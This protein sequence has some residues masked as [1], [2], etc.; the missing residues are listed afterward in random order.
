VEEGK[1]SKKTKKQQ[2]RIEKSQV[3]LPPPGVYPRFSAMRTSKNVPNTTYGSMRKM[4]YDAYA[5]MFKNH[6]VIYAAINK[7]AAVAVSGGWNFNGPTTDVVPSEAHVRELSNF[8]RRSNGKQLMRL[9]FMD[10]DIFGE[11]FWL[12]VRGSDTK[13]TPIKA[14][15]LE[16]KYVSEVVD[17]AG[18]LSSWE[19]G[20][21]SGDT[22]AV[23][24]GLDEVIQYKLDDPTDPIRGFS[25]LHSLQQAVAQDLFAMEY[26][27][28]F[29]KNSAQTGI[30]FIVKTSTKEEAD[31]NRAWIEENYAGPENAHRPLLIEGDVDVKQ[32]VSK[33]AEM[34]FLAGRKLL[35]Q[36]MLMALEVDPDKVGIHEDSNRSVS[37]EMEEAFHSQ[38]IAP[39]QVV[40]EE[41]INNQ[42]ILDMY[43]W[44]DVVI[45]HQEGD[46]RQAMR[47][48]EM[49][50]ENV[51]GGRMTI[52]AARK[53][54]GQPAVPGGDNAFINSP[55]GIVFVE[56]FDK[57]AQEQV[58]NAGPLQGGIQ[59]K[60]KQEQQSRDK[61]A[62]VKN[63]DPQ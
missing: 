9:T 31:R 45:D 7:K 2:M 44:D 10:L 39:R 47:D 4:Q 37:K 49:F 13:R 53:A 27:K 15:R 16:P 17:G 19:Y 55:T 8:M 59:A 43:G 23:S 25:P 41:G 22:T 61:A 1:M 14:L 24:Y 57:M 34:E 54:Q 32:S 3:A 42:L 12:I 11:S 51:Y 63:N 30:V 29:F 40:I 5:D 18:M 62:S 52:N 50:N 58:K 36:E 20:P 48:T 33:P 6:P 46:P 60:E 56:A 21:V 28:N 35:R 26:N 38:T